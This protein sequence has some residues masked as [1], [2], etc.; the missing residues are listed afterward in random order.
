MLLCR[1]CKT[2]NEARGLRGALRRSGA[3]QVRIL[4]R[5]DGWLVEWRCRAPQ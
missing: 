3:Q 1:M 5:D 4:K 2:Y